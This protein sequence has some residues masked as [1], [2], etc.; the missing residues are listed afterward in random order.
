MSTHREP[1]VQQKRE[2]RSAAHITDSKKRTGSGF[3]GIHKGKSGSFYPL[4]Q[5]SF[6]LPLVRR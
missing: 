5:G 6:E 4:S 2:A 1:R 3:K